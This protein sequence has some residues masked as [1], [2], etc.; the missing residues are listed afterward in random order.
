M[1]R[2]GERGGTLSEISE[3]GGVPA[4]PS[5]EELTDALREAVQ[6]IERLAGQCGLVPYVAQIAR[7][8]ALINNA[9]CAEN[10]DED[11]NSNT[12]GYLKGP[13]S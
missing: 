9:E 13:T 1:R 6:S 5:R 11:H 10:T 8:K 2:E 12:W 3:H 4:N 7:F